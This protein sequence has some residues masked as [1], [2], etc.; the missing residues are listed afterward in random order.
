MPSRAPPSASASALSKANAKAQRQA[1][2]DASHAI[3]KRRATG[4][5]FVGIGRAGDGGPIHGAMYDA[6]DDPDRLYYSRG[7]GRLDSEE[8]SGDEDSD[9]PGEGDDAWDEIEVKLNTSYLEGMYATD[10]RDFGMVF[11]TEPRY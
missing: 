4:R 8:D 10:L 5:S 3:A 1:G 9:V 11:A 2:L 6:D 7:L